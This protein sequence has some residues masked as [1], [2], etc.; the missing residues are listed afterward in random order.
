MLK[1]CPP[2]ERQLPEQV[3][4]YLNRHLH[5]IAHLAGTPE[6]IACYEG[7]IATFDLTLYHTEA[8]SLGLLDKVE[9]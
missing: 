4:G 7:D 3:T 6:F 2:Q 5:V 1:S 8:E 9:R